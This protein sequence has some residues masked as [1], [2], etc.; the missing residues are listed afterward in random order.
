MY[1]IKLREV[2]N[3]EKINNY[4]VNLYELS[5]IPHGIL[6]KEG[7]VISQAGFYRVCRDFHKKNPACAKRCVNSDINIQFLDNFNEGPLEYLCENGLKEIAFPLCVKGNYLGSLV[8]GQFFTEPPSLE[9]FINQAKLFGFNEEQYLE[10]IKE[11]PIFSKE[12]LKKRIKYFKS[13]SLLLLEQISYNYRLKEE[14][15]KLLEINSK[16]QCNLEERNKQLEKYNKEL[17]QS[18]ER[19]KTIFSILP[20]SIILTYNGKITYCNRAAMK[21]LGVESMKEVENKSL[22]DYFSFHNA[23]ENTDNCNKKIIKEENIDVIEKILQRKINGEVLYTEICVKAVR[24]NMKK[25]GLVVI[26]EITNSVKAKILEKNIMEKEKM[27]LAA[28]QYEELRTEFFANLSHEFR[29]PLNIILGSLKMIDVL[30]N[31]GYNEKGNLIKF[32]QYNN[33]I[34][35]NSFRLIRLINNL[36]DITKI[37]AGYLKLNLVNIDFIEIVENITQSVVPYAKQKGIQLIFDTLVEE[38]ILACDPD[39]I[40]RIVLNLL[41]NAIKFTEIGGKILVTIEE[42]NGELV[43]TVE[44]NGVGIPE[45]KLKDIFERFVQVDKTLSRNREGSGIGLSL[46]KSLVEMHGG[47]VSLESKLSIGSKFSFTIPIK[48]V[49]KD[50]KPCEIICKSEIIDIEFSDIYYV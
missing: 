22:L 26:R 18:K 4:L 2:L 35:Q 17:V 31:K 16:L 49:L 37:D 8:F 19:Y 50:E 45:D 23:Q 7:N 44:D 34:R 33:L 20:D 38:K 11:V 41:S 24:Y 42:N 5:G 6:D 47:N 12:E 15:I 32:K 46:I 10:A 29:T 14:E 40:E 28:K 9:Y 48:K 43:T 27:L 36:I 1:D 3:I 30:N 25:T 13:L 21:L 39:K